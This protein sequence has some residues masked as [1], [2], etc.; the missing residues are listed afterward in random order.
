MKKYYILVLLAIAAFASGRAEAQVVIPDKQAIV[1]SL[2]KIDP[3]IQRYF[4][5]WKICEPDLQRQ[6]YQA[7]V[8]F[9]FEKSELSEDNIQ[10]LAAPKEYDNDPYEILLI[11]CGSASMNA[12]EIES[13]LSDILMQFISGELIYSGANRGMKSES[14]KRD[15][16]FSDVPME[17]PLSSSQAEVIISYLEPTNVT[18][19]IVL[20]LFDQ[21]LKIGDSGFWLR[22]SL[23]TD[24]VGYPF[25]SSGESR[26]TLQRPLYVNNDPET[27]KG[28]PYLINAHLGG[29][30]RITGGLD[31]NSNI[32]SWVKS[33]SLNGGTGGKFIAGFDFHMPFHPAA[34]ISINVE[35]PFEN[36]NDTKV[37]S[38]TWALYSVANRERKVDFVDGDA[39]KDGGITI[40]RVAPVMRG[41]GQITAF[42]HWWLD[43]KNPENYFR[44]DIGLSYSE[45]REMAYYNVPLQYWTENWLSVNNIT[46]LQTYKPNELGDWLYAKAE[47]RNQATFPFGLSAQVSNQIFLGR[48]YIPLFGN[49]FYLEGKYATP[50]RK[51]RPYESDGFFM[52]SPVLRL[53]I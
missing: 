52:I 14:S 26:V 3:E 48:V 12:V 27:R 11:T 39:R 25:W 13:N 32:L 16:C 8:Y 4:P 28:I 49:W 24:Q 42:Y 45:V 7:F 22:S 40:D 2:T 35:L 33:R 51:A 1:D 46:G 43:K 21:S 6:L 10:V 17:V 31:G 34:G 53:T 20:S 47:F 36:M 30:Y 9:G 41:T 44:F 38:S 23:G 37:D 5:R 19:S 15:Y 29:G 50:L 18:H